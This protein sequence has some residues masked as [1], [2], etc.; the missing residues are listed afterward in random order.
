VVPSR[1][2]FFAVGSTLFS[3]L[4]LRGRM[5]PAWL[6][7]WGVLASVLLVLGLP[8]QVAGFF[9]GPLTGY[10]WVPAIGFTLVLGRW[11]VIKGV[12]APPRDERLGAARVVGLTYLGAL[13]PAIFAEFYVRG[14][15]VV[16]S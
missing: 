4:L 5:V 9:T 11:L 1:A 2:I 14:Q 15:L 12:A 6:A 16:S 3:Y 7:G 10:Q 13:A 8:L